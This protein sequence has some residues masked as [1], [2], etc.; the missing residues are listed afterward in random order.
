M[1]TAKSKQKAVPLTPI[2]S[3]LGISPAAAAELLAMLTER[4][5]QVAGLMATG[6]KNRKL[7]TDLGISSKTL[8]IH[9]ANVKRKLNAKTA[10]DI[11]RVVFASRFS[12]YLK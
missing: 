12:K 5:Q 2:E 11:A 4:E 7:A 10:V 6:M 9:R 3:I 8:D 1:A